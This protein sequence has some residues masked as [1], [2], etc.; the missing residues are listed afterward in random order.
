PTSLDQPIPWPATRQPQQ[1]S[2]SCADD[3]SSHSQQSEAE[4]FGLPPACRGRIVEC[5]CL[6]PRQQITSQ[7]YDLDPDPIL[8]EPIQGQIR[9]T[10]VFETPDPVFAPSPLSMPDFKSGKPPA[11]AA[12][13]GGKA[14][15][16][17]PIVI[18]QPQLRTGVRTFSSSND[19]HPFWPVDRARPRRSLLRDGGGH[20]RGQFS[21]LRTFA[22][23]AITVKGGLPRLL[24][25]DLDCCFDSIL[26]LESD[27]ILQPQIRDPVHE[28]FRT[29]PR[30]STDEDLLSLVFGE[31]CL[32]SVEDAQVLDTLPRRGLARTQVDG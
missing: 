9:K 2:T 21:D 13:V 31:L 8:P 24:G 27:R 17:P 1:P 6:H 23:L 10:G 26:S 32:R 22:G 7:S 28:R 14:G 19:A 20:P 29:R 5:Q 3:P 16:P 15:D 18:G 4:S 25:N 12:G 30:V 11:G